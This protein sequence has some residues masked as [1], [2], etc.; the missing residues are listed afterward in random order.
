MKKKDFKQC[1][2]VNYLK[3]AIAEAEIR[4]DSSKLLQ[5][6]RVP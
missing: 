6:E 3:N 2:H 4:I 5:A 1:L